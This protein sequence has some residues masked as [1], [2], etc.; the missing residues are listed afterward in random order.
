MDEVAHEERHILYSSQ[1]IIRL[2]ISRKVRWAGHMA[3]MGEERNVYR[4]LVGKPEGKRPLERPRHIWKG[5]IRMNLREIGW[6]SVEWFQ[7]AH[8]RD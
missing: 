4:V 3:S 7:M 2:I 6:G 1:N 8:D 5:G